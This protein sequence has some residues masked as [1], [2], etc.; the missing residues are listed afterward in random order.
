LKEGTIGAGDRIEKIADGPERISVAEINSLLYS[1]EHPID[2]LRRA[3]RIP[4]L[5]P[6][7]QASLKALLKAAEDGRSTG[8]AG[9]SEDALALARDLKH[10]AIMPCWNWTGWFV[11]IMDQHG[12]KVDEVPI[13]DV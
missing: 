9:L 3:V 11:A 8:N 6:G 5:S 13:A 12:H 1:P 2:A 7:W 10:G 4:A